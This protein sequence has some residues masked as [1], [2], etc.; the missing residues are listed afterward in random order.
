MYSVSKWGE[1][2]FIV[3]LVFQNFGEN[4]NKIFWDAYSLPMRKSGGFL[5]G[6]G[7][8]MTLLLEDNNGEKKKSDLTRT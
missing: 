3:T 4:V 2:I 5:R 7:G 1:Q 6:L 8:Q